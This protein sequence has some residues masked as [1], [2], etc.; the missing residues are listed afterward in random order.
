[1]KEPAKNPW[2]FRFF[3]PVIWFLR[4]P[5]FWVKIGSIMFWELSIQG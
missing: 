2:W 3:D 1:M 4:S 5:R